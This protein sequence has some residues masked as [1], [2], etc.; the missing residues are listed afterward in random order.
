MASKAHFRPFQVFRGKPHGPRVS[1]SR[2]R[3]FGVMLSAM[4]G[5]SLFAILTGSHPCFADASLDRAKERGSLV[6]AFE[7]IF[8]PNVVLWRD[9]RTGQFKGIEYEMLKFF[10]RELGVRLEV[11]P[12]KW[13]RIPEAVFQR[14]A[15]IGV[16]E[17]FIPPPGKR[18]AQEAWSDPY[19][20]TGLSVAFRHGTRLPAA[21]VP[22]PSARVAVL[23]DPYALDW[24]NEKGYRNLKVFDLEK[25]MYDA[26]VQGKVDFVIYDRALLLGFVERNAEAVRLA[27]GILPK[28]EGHYGVLH[29][30]EDG[31]LRAAINQAIRTWKA[32]PGT[33]ARLKGLG[34]E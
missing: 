1:A 8:D 3:S 27:P 34:L 14:Q 16:Q 9:A 20:K 15:D 5:M 7:S 31:T 17:L 29:R 33:E 32:T 13:D 25:P 12:T 2:R 22:P 24:C 23:N 21:Q 28:S 30:R 11:H 18:R 10:A 6:V 19:L 4:L 26:L